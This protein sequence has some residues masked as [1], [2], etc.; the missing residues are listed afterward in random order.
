MYVK[1]DNFIE[2]LQIC[3]KL[4]VSNVEIGIYKI[5]VVVVSSFLRM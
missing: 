5:N 2:I 3:V 4:K 1:H